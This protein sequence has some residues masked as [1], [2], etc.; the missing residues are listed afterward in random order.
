MFQRARRWRQSR[1]DKESYLGSEEFRQ[2]CFQFLVDLLRPANET[3]ARHPIA[4]SV[5]RFLGRRDERGMIGQAEIIVGAEIDHPPAIGD[6]NL[7]VLRSGD[8]ALGS[9]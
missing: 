9:E 2:S 4:V 6:R 8:D 7:G 3:H 5:E 1:K